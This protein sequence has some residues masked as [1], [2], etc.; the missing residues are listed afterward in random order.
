MYD[1]HKVYE[2]CNRL[3]GYLR[4]YK[5][6]RLALPYG[7]ACGNSNRGEFKKF[8]YQQ[9]AANVLAGNFDIDTYG[10][11]VPVSSTEALTGEPVRPRPWD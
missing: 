2:A 3:D 1:R 4:R 7:N 9:I 5:G 10:I 6:K 8:L 11:L